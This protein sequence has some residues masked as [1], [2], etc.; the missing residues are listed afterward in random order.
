MDDDK[1]DT[2]D[3]LIGV[4]IDVSGSM[5]V[6]VEGKIDKPENPMIFICLQGKIS[7]V[8]REDR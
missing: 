8:S 2:M 1:N 7:M 3:A 6:N 4:I 5:R